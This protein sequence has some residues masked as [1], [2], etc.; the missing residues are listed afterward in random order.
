MFH[1]LGSRA[2]E[3]RGG[4]TQEACAG[5]VEAATKAA[6]SDT[7][8]LRLVVRRGWPLVVLLVTGLSWCGIAFSQATFTAASSNSRATF[9]SGV[10]SH[11]NSRSGG[12]I[13][14]ATGMRPGQSRQ[15][16]VRIT[17]SGTLAGDFSL[18]ATDIIDTPGPNG[19]RL[20]DVLRLRIDRTTATAYTVYGGLL[21]DMPEIA[22]GT[23]DPRRAATFRFTVTFPD[24]GAAASETEGDNRYQRSR[25]SVRYLWT[26]T[27]ALGTP[28]YLGVFSQSTD[29]EAL[30]GYALRAGSAPPQPA[31]TGAGSVTRV[32][33]GGHTS[34]TATWVNR[35]ITVEAPATLPAGVSQVRVSVARLTDPANTTRQ[36]LVTAVLNTVGTDRG[37]ATSVV[38][39]PGEKRQLNVRVRMNTA[40]PQGVTYRPS[41]LVQVRDAATTG[42]SYA[43]VVPVSVYYGTGPG[44]D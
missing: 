36:P 41:L 19:G 8:R 17:N 1:S 14:T 18:A 44:P 42:P 29:P 31:A 21:K 34:T 6:H 3:E 5:G 4:R 9:T 39:G 22:L 32:H 20:S 10:L 2:R 7:G 24:G 38:L 25:T 40:W 28:A 13:L 33:L 43:Y 35:V 30:T 23:W 27:S 16:T 11:L 37:S 26:Q 12:A 15:G